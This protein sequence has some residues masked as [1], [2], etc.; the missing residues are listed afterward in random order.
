MLLQNYIEMIRVYKED[1]LLVKILIV[2]WENQRVL[3]MTFLR[4]DKEKK[5]IF[6][7]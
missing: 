1:Y 2:S 5:C 4:S 6:I 7:L 3:L